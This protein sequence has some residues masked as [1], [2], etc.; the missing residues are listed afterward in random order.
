[1]KTIITIASTGMFVRNL[2]CTDVRDILRMAGVRL[3][4]LAPAEKLEYYRS[5]YTDEFLEF[6][7]L[8][9]LKKMM[10]ERIFQFFENSSIHTRT[11]AMLQRT[12]FRRF[13]SRTRIIIRLPLFLCVRACWHLG[14]FFWWRNTIRR[15]Y[16]HVPNRALDKIIETYKPD[17]IFCPSM[18]YT[19][20]YVLLKA[21]KRFSIATIGMV[22]SW[23][24]F[25]SKTFLR[26]HPDHL[27]VHTDMIRDLAVQYG[28][29]PVSRILV[30]GVPQYDRHFRRQGV[31]SREDF[32][33]G[34][35]GNPSKK[36]IVYAFSGKS[37]LHIDFDIL[38]MIA[39]DLKSGKIKEEV[40]VLIRPYPKFDMKEKRAEEF[41]QTYGF[42]V[43]PV[44]THV[45]P[46]GEYDWEFD[47]S[48]SDLLENT[49]VHADVII[50][51]YST[52]FIEGAI[53]D[54][55]LI[56]VGF[57]GHKKNLDYD[58]SAV[59]FFDW[60]HLQDIKAL[61]GIRI[62]HNRSELI[63]AINAYLVHPEADREGRKKIAIQQC[64]FTDGMS[65]RR[66]ASVLLDQLAD[67]N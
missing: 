54:K 65:A 49:L 38:D 58:N 26:M 46:K 20:D 31:I 4:I 63:D 43:R 51:M 17:L 2:V 16:A 53:M 41:R 52:F 12:K 33:R 9:L 27:I 21:A 32:I 14:K 34:L 29:Y 47:A 42:L 23:D 50:S 24:N 62:A 39:I 45:G 61:G 59:R 18:F 22:L 11:A 19:E 10:R 30:T 25:Y 6:A 64:Q 44:V 48:A 55:P 66:I 5:E 57:D 36:L 60:N 28:D 1:M 37:G 13:G 15:I 67:R 3:V 40:N 35:G 7:E 56:A 8:P